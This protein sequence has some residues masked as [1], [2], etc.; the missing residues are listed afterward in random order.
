MVSLVETG[1]QASE[2]ENQNHRE[3]TKKRFV[4]SPAIEEA[5]TLRLSFVF[6]NN[7]IVI[8]RCVSMG[9]TMMN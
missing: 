2:A 9:N 7:Q 5:K 8:S 1:S 4:H 3:L 6:V